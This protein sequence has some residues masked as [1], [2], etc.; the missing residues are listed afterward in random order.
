M[1]PSVAL[2]LG[3]VSNLP[4]IWSNTL[5]GVALAGGQLW[6]VSTLWLAIGLSLLY[7]AGMFLNDAFDRDIDALER[8]ER[9]I[10]AGLVSANTVFAAGFGLM[11][12]WHAWQLAKLN[13]TLTTPALEISMGWLYAALVAG[14]VLLAICA[15]IAILRP[16]APAAPGHIAT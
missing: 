11:L 4:T 1:T 10:P 2:R 16:Q 15:I 12:A 9:P 7:T 14:G 8:P 3:R 5:A 13:A 6:T